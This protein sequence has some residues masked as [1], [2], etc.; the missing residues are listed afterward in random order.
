M[1][2]EHTEK[3]DHYSSNG[4]KENSRETVAEVKID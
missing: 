4:L 2:T 3:I 1:E